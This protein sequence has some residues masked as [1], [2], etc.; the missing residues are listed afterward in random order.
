[1]SYAIAIVSHYFN[2]DDRIKIHTEDPNTENYH[3]FDS[4][5]NAEVW[6]DT[7]N[8][9][10][11][12]L[13]HNEASRP[14]Y[15]VLDK[16]DAE[17]I[18]TGRNSDDTNYDWDEIDEENCLDSETDHACGECLYCSRLKTYQNIDFA[19]EHAV[20]KAH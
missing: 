3:V 6:V 2:N 15:Y 11:Y 9:N 13:Q 1:M 4:I 17:Y 20:S 5:R 18:Y 10:P 16:N 12:T 7:R 8:N 14:E 19:K